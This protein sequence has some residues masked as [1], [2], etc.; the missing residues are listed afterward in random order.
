MTNFIR[1]VWTDRESSSRPSDPEPDIISSRQPDNC[2]EDEYSKVYKP[3]ANHERIKFLNKM[4]ELSHI[5][6]LFF[7]TLKKNLAQ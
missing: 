7:P 2:T 1:H 6:K 5:G 3:F 4:S